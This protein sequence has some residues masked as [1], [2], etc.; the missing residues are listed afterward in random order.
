MIICATK[1]ANAEVKPR[2]NAGLLGYVQVLEVAHWTSET[3][4]AI[5]S[6]SWN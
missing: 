6:I 3:Y 4:K 2:A 1:R 5:S